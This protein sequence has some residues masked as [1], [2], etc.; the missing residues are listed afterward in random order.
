MREVK[1]RFWSNHLKKLVTPDDSIFVGALKDPDMN[2]MQYTGLKDKNE[3]EVYE[4]DLFDPWDGRSIYAVEWSDT[5]FGWQLVWKSG[6]VGDSKTQ[7]YFS[8]HMALVLPVIGNIQEN[9]EL[10]NGGK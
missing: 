2:P 9:P 1:F 3:L 10:V 8:L 6:D 4:G 7:H 5:S